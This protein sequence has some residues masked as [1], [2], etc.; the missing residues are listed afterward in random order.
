MKDR[1]AKACRGFVWTKPMSAWDGVRGC[2]VFPVG[3]RK[4][5]D[6]VCD[7][8]GEGTTRWVIPGWS[9]ECVRELMPLTL[10]CL[11][12]EEPGGVPGRWIWKP[13]SHPVAV[14]WFRG[15]AIG[16]EG[17]SPQGRRKA[18]PMFAIELDW[19]K[20][21]A[22]RQCEQNLQKSFKMDF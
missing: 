17:F 1:N 7:S 16:L 21:E 5:A 14:L 8:S 15:K 9:R 20:D 2:L 3:V 18:V 4:A 12:G 10:L 6:R 13:E 19:N 22:E 11:E